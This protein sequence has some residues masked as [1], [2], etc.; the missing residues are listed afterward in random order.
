MHSNSK[1]M[2]ILLK[3]MHSNSKKMRILLKSLCIFFKRMYNLFSV[4]Q[5]VLTFSHAHTYRQYTIKQLL[6]SFT[7]P[8]LLAFGARLEQTYVIE[9]NEQHIHVAHIGSFYHVDAMVAYGV[10]AAK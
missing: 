1:R 6:T 7:L 10:L 2:R 9:V 8:R 3:S 5:H 4:L